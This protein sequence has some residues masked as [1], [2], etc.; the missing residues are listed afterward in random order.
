MVQAVSN[1]TSA[2]LRCD[3]EQ[4]VATAAVPITFQ[5]LIEQ[6]VDCFNRSLGLDPLVRLHASDIG[7]RGIQV[8]QDV[9]RRRGINVGSYADAL[10][11]PWITRVPPSIGNAAVL[12]LCSR[13]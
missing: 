7:K 6:S 9:L 1:T 4:A 12:L 11:Y 10:G 13:T 3:P 8:L 2:S 5:R